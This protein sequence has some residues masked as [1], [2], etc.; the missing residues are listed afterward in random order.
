M[1]E[2]SRGQ[3]FEQAIFWAREEKNIVCQVAFSPYFIL[4][5]C[6]LKV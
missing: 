5:I 6:V 4:F 1:A 2:S 3:G